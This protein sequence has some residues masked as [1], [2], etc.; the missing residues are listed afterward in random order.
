MDATLFGYEGL[1]FSAAAA[2]ARAIVDACRRHGGEAVLL[3]HNS[4]LQGPRWRAH[5]QELV[6]DLVRPPN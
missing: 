1:G 6:Q 3:Y 5:Y 4:T 2:K